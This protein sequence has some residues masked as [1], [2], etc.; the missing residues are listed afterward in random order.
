VQL[1]NHHEAIGI[2]GMDD[3]PLVNLTN[4]GAAI[5]GGVDRCVSEL[6]LGAIDCRLVGLDGCLLLGNERLLGELRLL[7]GDFLGDQVGVPLQVHP[8]IGQL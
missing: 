1:R 3:I 7:R 6:D 2:G 8:G 4:A 5:K